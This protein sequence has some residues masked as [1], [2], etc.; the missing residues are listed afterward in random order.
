V[1]D[2]VR[3][4]FS[5][6]RVG[7]LLVVGF[8]V[9]HALDMAPVGNRVGGRVSRP[10]RGTRAMSAVLLALSLAV[11]CGGRAEDPGESSSPQVPE[12]PNE[13]PPATV[14]PPEM[15][16]SQDSTIPGLPTVEPQ[17]PPMLTPSTPV[18]E[19]PMAPNTP[20]TDPEPEMDPEPEI[21]AES[22]LNEGCL[23]IGGYVRVFVYQRDA[24]ANVCTNLTL[25]SDDEVSPFD[26]TDLTVPERWTVED[27]S[28]YPCLPEGATTSDAIPTYFTRAS[29]SIAF[30]AAP[31]GLPSSMDIDV[32]L[33]VPAEDVGTLPEQMIIMDRRIVARNLDLAGSCTPR[34]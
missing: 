12:L 11:A 22:L 2:K 29:G 24:L 28:A 8:V 9:D 27:M 6:S 23:Y 34:R 17:A 3:A 30:A 18:P 16:A 20:D 7:I 1:C 21:P 31:L 25:I 33:S 14:V 15:Q 19:P 32:R 4:I 10:E 5:G 13:E 26:L